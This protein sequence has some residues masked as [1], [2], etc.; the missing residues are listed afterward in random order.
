MAELLICCYRKDDAANPDI[1]ASALVALFCDYPESIVRRVSDPR[2]G[3]PGKQKFFPSIAEIRHECE[4]HAKRIADE[5]AWAAREYDR[6]HTLAPPEVDRA[7]V[8]AKSRAQHP[9]IYDRKRQDREAEGALAVSA[10][11]SPAKQAY[12]KSPLTV[13][14]ALADYLRR[15]P[16][17]TVSPES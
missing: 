8:L 7:A 9:E 16:I 14:P 13:G 15:N 1:F 5:E 12:W 10:L 17:E 11:E 3:I 2:T 4:A 6:A